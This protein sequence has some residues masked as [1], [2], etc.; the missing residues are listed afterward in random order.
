MI[1]IFD[2][3]FR[4]YYIKIAFTSTRANELTN[5]HLTYKFLSHPY[6]CLSQKGIIVQDC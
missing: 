2:M 1:F 3:S 4:N 5:I 6:A